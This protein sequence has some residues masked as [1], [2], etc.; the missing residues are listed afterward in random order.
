MAGMQNI[1]K[2]YREEKEQADRPW[3]RKVQWK[4]RWRVVSG[5]CY[6]NAWAEQPACSSG[7]GTQH[8]MPVNS[9]GRTLIGGS[10]MP[11]AA[12]VRTGGTRLCSQSR[13]TAAGSRTEFWSEAC[14]VS[15]VAR[16]LGSVR[17]GT[18]GNTHSDGATTVDLL[19]NGIPKHTLG[20]S[21]QI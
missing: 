14:L 9:V 20:H 10:M 17:I 5:N 11:A 7:R 6:R 2:T 12:H 13:R 21:D 15:N 18:S 1:G 3:R 19:V 8:I 4:E 16:L